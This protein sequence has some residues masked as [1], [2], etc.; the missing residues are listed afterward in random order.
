MKTMFCGAL[1][2]VKDLFMGVAIYA[3]AW[4][5]SRQSLGLILA[6]ASVCAWADG[7]IVKGL[8]GTGEWNHWG[9]GS[10]IGMLGVYTLLT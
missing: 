9:Y 2:G 6:M 3:S 4:L 7:F 1:F 10:A 8:A 5:G